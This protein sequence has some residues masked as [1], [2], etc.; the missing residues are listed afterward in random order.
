[1]RCDIMLNVVRRMMRLAAGDLGLQHRDGVAG[2]SCR[3][4]TSLGFLVQQV[5][6]AFCMF[7]VHQHF[8]GGFGFESDQ[9]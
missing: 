7:F 6:D 1:M 9:H 4:D 5:E 8:G 3:D 2:F